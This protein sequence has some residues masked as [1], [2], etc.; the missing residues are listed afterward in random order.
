MSNTPLSIHIEVDA[1]KAVKALERL[2]DGLKD[3]RQM[4]RIGAEVAKFSQER[5]LGRK[6]TAPDGSQWEPLAAKTLLRKKKRGFGH[7]GTLQQRNILMDSL[8]F[9]NATADSVDVGSSCV[10]AM[11]HQKGGK[12]GRGGKVTIPARPYIGLSDGDRDY[13]REFIQDWITK[14]LEDE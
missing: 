4:E 6:N 8:T 5:I 9:G 1:G 10:Y 13:M 3:P 7:Q 2:A 14:L 12:A 11:V